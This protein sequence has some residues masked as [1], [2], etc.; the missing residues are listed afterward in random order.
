MSDV[1]FF[2]VDAFPD[3]TPHNAL[4][5]CLVTIIE[6]DSDH[7]DGTL[8]FQIIGNYDEIM[9]AAAALDVDRI[10]QVTR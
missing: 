2:E 10:E 8:A 4:R 9:M 3:D 1:Y 7:R 5:H 6:V